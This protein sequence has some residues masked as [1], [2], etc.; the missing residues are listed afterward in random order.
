MSE[1]AL[2]D[3][4]QNTEK[5]ANRSDNSEKTSSSGTPDLDGRR[6]KKDVANEDA[7]SKHRPAYPNETVTDNRRWSRDT[8]GEEPSSTKQFSSS[9]DREV[10]NERTHS[11]SRYE[12]GDKSREMGSGRRSSSRGNSWSWKS[13][14]SGNL[15]GRKEEPIAR[16]GFSRGYGTSHY[17]GDDQGYQR[18]KPSSSSS[19]SN[20][21]SRSTASMNEPERKF[22]KGL[23][24]GLSKV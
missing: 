16:R 1:A 7:A 12:G 22:S 3:P 9:R 17:K 24:V 23:C 15:K 2:K 13:G 18:S 6:W 10:R 5:N 8:A 19:S 4:P 21:S 11:A 14:P 20:L